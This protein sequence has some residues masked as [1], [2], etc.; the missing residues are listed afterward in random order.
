M[1]QPILDCVCMASIVKINGSV[2][3][4]FI[5]LEY[6][7]RRTDHRM[8]WHDVAC[9]FTGAPVGDAAKHF[10]QRFNSNKVNN[11]RYVDFEPHPCLWPSLHSS[12]NCSSI[13]VSID[14]YK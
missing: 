7:D 13:R 2:Y 3:A 8:P 4:G 14:G 12:D 9:S 6:M 10:I 11:L 1:L 5:L